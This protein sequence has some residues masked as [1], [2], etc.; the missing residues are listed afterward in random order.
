MRSFA[1]H[2][3]KLSTHRLL[4]SSFPLPSA[5]ARIAH[6]LLP[7]GIPPGKASVA[8]QRSLHTIQNQHPCSKRVIRE[9]IVP[10][11]MDYF[12]RRLTTLVPTPKQILARSA[13]PAHS[14]PS[15]VL[16]HHFRPMN[17]RHPSAA[18]TRMSISAT[19]P[20]LRADAVKKA[21]SSR[22]NAGVRLAPGGLVGSFW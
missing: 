11:L 10:K 1:S 22:P 17:Y 4:P 20:L 6:V 19:S 14:L 13:A 21:L 18:R 15:Y 8:E 5:G 7:H 9:E 2:C 12:R 3:L 16:P